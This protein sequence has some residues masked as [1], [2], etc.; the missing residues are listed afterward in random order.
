MSASPVVLL[1][2]AKGGSGTTTL[3][4]ELA[5]AIGE[6]GNAAVVDADLTGRRSMALLFESLRVLDAARSAAS[7]IS[8]ARLDGVTIVELADRY[9]AAFAL[10]VETVETLA[11]SLSG[12][13]A[14][15]VDAPQPFAAPVRPFISRAARVLI[16][17]EPT[18]LGVAGAQTM[19][20]DLQRF[21]VPVNRVALV[22]Q[23][24]QRLRERAARRHRARA[25]SKGRRGD[26]AVVESRLMRRASPACSDT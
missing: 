22:T 10:D 7:P 26:S 2:G 4:R 5:R 21:G 9:D 23:R 15:L 20:A 6:K 17:L 8:R 25:R 3:C 14:V 13:N 11:A 18:L 16:V 12:F 19:F 24:P 1:T